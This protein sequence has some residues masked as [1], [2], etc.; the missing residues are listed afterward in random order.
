MRV[1]AGPVDVAMPVLT[2]IDWIALAIALLAF[3]LAFRIK[4]GT[5]PLLAICAA[6]GL[7]ATQATAL[8]P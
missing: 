5:L 1:G 4:L 8:T 7:V 6:A 3:V 2:S